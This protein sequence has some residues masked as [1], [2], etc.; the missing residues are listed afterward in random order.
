MALGTGDGIWK[1]WSEGHI[2]VTPAMP[3]YSTGGWGRLVLVEFAISE[4]GATVE[5]PEQYPA[6]PP[7]GLLLLVGDKPLSADAEVVWS[8]ESPDPVVPSHRYGLMFTGFGPKDQLSLERTLAAA[9]GGHEVVVHLGGDEKTVVRQYRYVIVVADL[10]RMR[11]LYLADDRGQ[12][13]LDGF[14]RTLTAARGRVSTRSPVTRG[15]PTFSR[16]WPIWTAPGEDPVGQLP[17]REVCP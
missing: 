15:S 11:V 13:S 5:L 6:G 16:R 10:D 12:E 7:L 8:E 2:R 1:G 14:W 17:H 3:R 4:G 9:R